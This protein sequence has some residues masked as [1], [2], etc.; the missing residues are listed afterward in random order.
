MT[1]A[2][3]I[4]Y[5][6][7][8][9]CQRLSLL[10]W[11]E[12]WGIT[13]EDFYKFLAAGQEHFEDAQSEKPDDDWIPCSAVDAFTGIVGGGAGMTNSDAIKW[14]DS[15]RE[16]IGNP[17]NGTL[18][19]YEQSLIEIIDILKKQDWI[20]CSKDM[21]EEFKACLVTDDAGGMKTVREDEFILVI[22]DDGVDDVPMWTISQNVT[23]WRPLPE[24]W[25]GE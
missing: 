11:C 1:K 20:P 19:H 23:A 15:L 22:G 2:E 16:A 12:D 8:K 7:K 14:I 24:P 4:S 5:A 18:W 25:E 6:I 13:I 3:T 21:P 17:L 10:D 9:E